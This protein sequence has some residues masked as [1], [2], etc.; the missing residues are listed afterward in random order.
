LLSLAGGALGLLLAYWA[1]DALLALRP[2]GLPEL[3]GVGVDG[4]VVAFTAG[5]SV[6]TGLLFGVLPAAQATRPA[7]AGSL[8]EGGRGTLGAGRGS[9]VR[10]G[11]GDGEMAV[12]V[13]LLAGAGLLI[14]GFVQLVR[15]EPG[16]G[17]EGVLAVN[18]TL[19][20]AS[21]GE[22]EEIEGFYSRLLAR[23]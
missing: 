16:C 1:T 6:L 10:G 2:P 17:R 3:D 23:L 8:R 20:P 11:L 22:P 21:Y 18:L 7:L 13:T 19:P 15:V 12:G 4:T 14:R 5:V 9:R